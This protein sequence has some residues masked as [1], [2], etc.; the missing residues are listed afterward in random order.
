MV[1]PALSTVPGRTL[2]AHS[3]R[4]G[5]AG[6]ARA[7][8]KMLERCCNSRTVWRKPA[9][10]NVVAADDELRRLVEV[11]AVE[12]RQ[13]GDQ[14]G[15]VGQAAAEGG[16]A[17]GR[18]GADAAE[19][20]D[21]PQTDA[22]LTHGAIVTEA[23]KVRCSQGAVAKPMPAGGPASHL[24][25]KACRASRFGRAGRSDVSRRWALPVGRLDSRSPVLRSTYRRLSQVETA[26][27]KKP[28]NASRSNCFHSRRPAMSE[29]TEGFCTID[30]APGRAA[31]RPHDRPRR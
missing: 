1:A 15:G 5:Q 4:S 18:R 25:A 17:E 13:G 6:S 3:S 23:R 10:A 29:T 8:S 2:A 22:T 19:G 12:Q 27:V 26:V 16:Q 9:A 14:A 21:Q 28:T 11:E 31:R 24:R 7:G 30:E 20:A